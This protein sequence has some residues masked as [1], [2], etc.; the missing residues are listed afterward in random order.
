[1]DEL[2]NENP[3]ATSSCEFFYYPHEHGASISIGID[4]PFSES[5]LFNE[6]AAIPNLVINDRKI[7]H[8]SFGPAE[9]WY[10][11]TTSLGTFGYEVVLE[12]LEEGY[13]VYS[14]DKQI[15]ELIVGRLRQSPYFH[16]R[17]K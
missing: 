6:I 1:M 17:T 15:M 13:S 10:E 5:T 8:Q 9:T 7:T 3:G 4:E 11:I 12:G 14:D 2:K 16:E